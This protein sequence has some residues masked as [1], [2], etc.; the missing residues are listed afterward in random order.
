VRKL[1]EKVKEHSD[2]HNSENEINDSGLSLPSLRTALVIG[3]PGHELMVHGWLK[4]TQPR[5]F[6]F[7]DGSGRSNQSRLGSTTRILNQAGAKS[8]GVYGR[9]TDAAAY[10]AILNHEFDLFLGLARELCEAFADEHIDYVAGDAFEG[11]NP[12]HDV[13]RLVIN[14]AVTLNQRLGGH[15]VGNLEFSLV[16]QPTA[17]HDQPHAGGICSFL[18]DAAF[19]QKMAAANGYPELAGEVAALK[20]TSTAALRVECL[21]PV[22]PGASYTGDQPPF[23]EVYGEKQVAAGHYRK[24]LRYH[25]HI[26]PLAE[27]L[28]RYASDPQSA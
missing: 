7:T 1:I 28:S 20:K 4:A 6:V 17:S 3:H 25:E 23:Y 21:R 8:S 22:G 19:A 9:L 15:R 11:Y 24:V 27:A 16:S 5:V 14:A 13:C 10:E 2:I 26:R 12:V 18:D